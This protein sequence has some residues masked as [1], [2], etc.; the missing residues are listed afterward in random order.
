ME[1]TKISKYYEECYEMYGDNHKGVDWPNQK[2]A[3]IRYRVMLDIMKFDSY[4]RKGETLLLIWTWI[5]MIYRKY[6]ISQTI[7]F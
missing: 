1:Y 5:K 4:Q 3:E 6:A 2:D 7:Q